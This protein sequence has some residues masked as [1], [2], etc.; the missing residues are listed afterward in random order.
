MNNVYFIIDFDSTFIKLEALEELAKIVLRNNPEKEKIIEK[1]KK[2]TKMGMEGKIPFNQS[3]KERI[4]LLKA[5]KSD[6]DKL[7]KILKKSITPSFLRNKIFFK[8]NKDKIYIISGGFKEYILPLIKYF[9][10]EEKNILAN[11][12]IF[13]KKNEIIGFDKKNFLSQ[14]NGKVKQ[15]KALNLKGKIYVVGDGYTD[16]QIKKYGLAEKFFLF[17]ENVKRENLL[18]LADYVLSN[19]D[20]FLDYL[21]IK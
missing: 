12:F 11:Q 21:K 13:N 2:I 5:R 19:F 8:K 10:L 18:N 9:G 3:L 15:I 7:I 6:L 17:C 20:E 16:Y 1:I 14:E 4:N